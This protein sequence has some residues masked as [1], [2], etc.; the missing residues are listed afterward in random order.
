M[1]P[2]ADT[3]KWIMQEKTYYNVLLPVI[4]LNKITVKANLATNLRY[5][6][7]LN[8]EL[9]AER[10]VLLLKAM[11]CLLA[12]R[13][14]LRCHFWKTIDKNEWKNQ[15]NTGKSSKNHGTKTH[16]RNLATFLFCFLLQCQ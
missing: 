4:K 10:K 5:L 13:H 15:I 9:V 8:F 16:D 1:Y 7:T 6:T 14:D 11:R 2:N 3:D 12:T